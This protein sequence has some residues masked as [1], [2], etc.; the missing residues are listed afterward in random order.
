VN[1]KLK[2]I[3][4]GLS[5]FAIYTILILILRYFS[6]FKPDDA[7]I[8]G[9]FSKNDILL[10]VLVAVVLTFSHERKKKLK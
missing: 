4:Y 1:S 10:G 8:L 3:L 9:V 6:H 2:P 7:E 5:V